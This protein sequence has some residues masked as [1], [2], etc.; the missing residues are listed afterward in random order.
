MPV[1]TLE[2]ANHDEPPQGETD[3]VTPQDDETPAIAEA[4]PTEEVSTGPEDDI[5][6]AMPEEVEPMPV[7]MK[8]ARG[9]PTGPPKPKPD[10]KK[11]GRPPFQKVEN[12]N[13]GQVRRTK[14]Q[15]HGTWLHT[16]SRLSTPLSNIP[17]P[18]RV[19]VALSGLP[20]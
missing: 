10:A 12:Q 2:N 1:I 11:R 17:N 15:L 19:S 8:K 16:I 7:V 20:L 9:R 6:L 4:E 3:A 14:H 18:H 5:E 13:Q